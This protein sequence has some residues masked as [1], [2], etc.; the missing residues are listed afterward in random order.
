MS[1][2]ISDYKT[3]I[4][5]SGIWLQDWKLLIFTNWAISSGHQMT[6]KLAS[7][8]LFFWNFIKDIYALDW[9]F[10]LLMISIQIVAN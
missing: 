7:Y 1:L 9:Y 8:G 5:E 4:L 3:Q 10:N 6:K 2:F